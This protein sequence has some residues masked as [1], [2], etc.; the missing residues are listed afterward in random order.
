MELLVED[1]GSFP[2]VSELS[3][4]LEKDKGL[5]QS[6]QRLKVREAEQKQQV[7][8]RQ[9]EQQKQREAILNAQKEAFSK[10]STFGN[11]ARKK[12]TLLMLSPKMEQET[13]GGILAGEK[14]PQPPQ[15]L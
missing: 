5:E 9:L 8:D 3:M 4:R 15:M 12:T 14:T 13:F 7:I 6:R 1:D 10:K 2:R 11:N